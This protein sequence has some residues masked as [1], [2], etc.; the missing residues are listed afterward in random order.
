MSEEYYYNMLDEEDKILAYELASEYPFTTEH[1]SRIIMEK[2][3][4]NKE[5]LRAYMNMELVD[6]KLGGVF[7]VF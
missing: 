5:Q 4:D 6:I 1:I 3:Y 7:G 2:G